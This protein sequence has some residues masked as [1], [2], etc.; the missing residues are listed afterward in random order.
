MFL[1]YLNG[2][3]IISG[4]VS[5]GGNYKAEKSHILAEKLI[6]AAFNLIENFSFYFR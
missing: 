6:F 5:E 1:N 3:K 2:L 4:I